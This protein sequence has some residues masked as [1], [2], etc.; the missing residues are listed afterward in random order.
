MVEILLYLEDPCY[1]T[2][3]DR[4]F[5]SERY[6]VKIF[7]EL[8]SLQEV[9][10]QEFFDLAIIWG[11]KSENIKE[12]T[13]FF[14]KNNLSYLPV[15][16][17]SE[18]KSLAK[19][20]SAL[21]ISDCWLLPLPR[22]EINSLLNHI[23]LDIDF[24]MNVFGRFNWQGSLEEYHLLNLIQMVSSDKR[25][26][27]LSISYGDASGK[28]FFNKG[29]LIHAQY[30]KLD[31]F[32]ALNKLVYW[33]RGH[34]KIMFSDERYTVQSLD[35]S[36][37]EILIEMAKI[38]ADFDRMYQHLPDMHE[39]IIC[40]LDASTLPS[41]L[42]QQNVLRMAEKPVSI[43]EVLVGLD[44]TYDI[45]IPE[46]QKLFKKQ[47]LIEK[48]KFKELMHLQKENGGFGKLFYTI[49]SVFKKKNNDREEDDDHNINNIDHIKP[50]IE[51]MQ[52]QSILPE[53]KRI[54]EKILVE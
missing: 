28:I 3:I 32:E 38:F 45:V 39:H 14:Q 29:K 17:I 33:Q 47:L 37:Q 12:L 46:L 31:G 43:F 53:Q 40:N 19:E 27:V 8:K 11:A 1:E 34:F 18:N 2:E 4:L 51:I 7:T 22:E 13:D 23:C 20:V 15:V 24:R 49:S 9:S 5:N 36:N 41:N 21:P 52:P 42:I 26:A 6:S 50:S 48:S 10:L 35:K 54:L 16:V 30:N 25:T 44:E